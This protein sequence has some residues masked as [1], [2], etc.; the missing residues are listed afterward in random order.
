MSSILQNIL[1]A[2]L[3]ATAVIVVAAIASRKRKKIH[4][5]ESD[6][7][8]NPEPKYDPQPKSDDKWVPASVA[9]KDNIARIKPLLH[10]VGTDGISN[11]EQWK[12]VIV[13]INNEDLTDM[14]KTA[15]SRPG[16]WLTYL[17]TFGLQRDLTAEFTCL[18]EYS[19]M[20]DDATS[21]QL[22]NGEKYIVVSPCWIYTNSDNNQ[23]VAVKGFVKKKD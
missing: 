8:P 21:K 1:W 13:S 18:P 6:T 14:W 23:E 20:Y 17:Q 11:A 22:I 12:E 7:V 16:L 9:F 19:E 5:P 4:K 3:G 15:I 2:A 10:G